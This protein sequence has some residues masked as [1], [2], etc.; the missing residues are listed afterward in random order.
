[1][2]GPLS[3]TTP[4]MKAILNGTKSVT[5]RLVP[6]R[7]QDMNL[8][9]DEIAAKVRNCDMYWC[10][11]THLTFM[12][13]GIK[14]VIYRADLDYEEYKDY[15]WRPPRFMPR[16]L[17]RVTIQRTRFYVDSLQNMTNEDAR[18]EGITEAI[19]PNLIPGREL[20]IFRSIWDRMSVM[21]EEADY[22]RSFEGNPLV[23]VIEF[24]VI[25]TENEQVDMFLKVK[26]KKK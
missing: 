2:I 3:F 9:N 21:D 26:G 14:N 7:Y 19:Y 15:K 6:V 20:G 8:T 13:N 11:E 23:S 5:R 24:D 16:H 10:R 25:R 17:S 22:W 12:K 4:M 18:L 1:M